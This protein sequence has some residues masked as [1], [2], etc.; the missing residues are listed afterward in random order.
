MVFTFRRGV[1]FCPRNSEHVFCF[2]FSRSANIIF[3]VTLDYISLSSMSSVAKGW[4]AISKYFSAT[5][6]F[7]AIQGQG[8]EEI[9]EKNYIFVIR[10]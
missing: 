6:S 8:D 9:I 1:A 7:V 2:L 5:P 4:T 3:S 10:I